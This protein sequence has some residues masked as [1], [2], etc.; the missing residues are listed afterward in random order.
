[1]ADST[2]KNNLENSPLVTD[3]TQA[4][5][6]PYN[7]PGFYF[8]LFFDVAKLA[9]IH[10]QEDLAKFGYRK[11]GKY[12]KNSRILFTFWLPAGTCCRILAI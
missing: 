10:S 1:V 6:S 2:K 7:D 8:I 4:L 5:D 11:I 9:I 12:R 3:S